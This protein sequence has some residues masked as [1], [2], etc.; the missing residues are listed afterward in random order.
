M[1][2]LHPK[3]PSSDSPP[4]VPPRPAKRPWP[5]AQRRKMLLFQG[6][7]PPPL[8]HPLQAPLPPQFE[9]SRRD[10]LNRYPQ[11]QEAVNWQYD[12][13]QE[14][15][16]QLSSHGRL[17]DIQKLLKDDANPGPGVDSHSWRPV[18][19][20]GKGTYGSVVLWERDTGDCDHVGL[21]FPDPCIMS[22]EGDAQTACRVRR[23][24]GRQIRQLLPG[25]LS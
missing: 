22:T 23:L 2:P 7:I 11:F 21:H 15:D 10:Q 3:T 17:T 19:A 9:A 24:Q 4:V 1:A 6:P 25:L 20:L 12:H 8:L 5:Q 18:M 14:G 13:L 16:I